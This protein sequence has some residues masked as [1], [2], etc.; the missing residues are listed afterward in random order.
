MV[1]ISR[2]YGSNPDYVIAGGGNTSFKDESTLLVKGSGTNLGEIG[3]EGF[4]TMDRKKLNRIWNKQYPADEDTREA[5][6]VLDMMAARADTEGSRR[7]SVETLL[8]N[9][10]PFAYVVHTHPSLVNGFACSQKG[11]AAAKEL[12]GD[13]YLWTPSINP[14]YSLS[15]A[16]KA[17]F[18]QHLARTGKTAE[19]IFLQNHGIFVGSDSIE[20]IKALYEKIIAVLEKKITRRPDFS[21]KTG[22]YKDSEEIARRL[23][24]CAGQNARVIFER[25][26]EF[27]RFTRS[28]ADF[29]PVS[30]AFSPDHMIYSG[31]DPLFIEIKDTQPLADQIR[32]AWKQHLDAI[33]IP[34]KIVAVQDRG[35]FGIGTSERNAALALALFTD[36]AKI[37]VY[38]EIFGGVR[39]MTRD[40]IDFINNWEV[41]KYRAQVNEG[42]R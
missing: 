2:Y 4:V 15:M 27:I 28:L 11:E 1:D 36:S 19:V 33:G 37:A 26:G 13:E 5:E 31:S 10:L 22:V 9:I 34:P 3:P 17:V 39:F 40:K 7:P 6:L 41:E 12:F 32:N 18:D 35:I 25:N 30:S 24:A 20:G 8:H 21:G 38:A 16:A 29:Y 23:T 14:G 42:G